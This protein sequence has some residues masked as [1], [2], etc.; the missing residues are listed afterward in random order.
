MKT[1]GLSLE[2]TYVSNSGSMYRVVEINNSLDV[3]IEFI[4]THRYRYSVRAARALSG[5][6]H[7]P[8]QPLKY[9][10]GYMGVG[11]YVSYVSGK[12]TIAYDVWNDMLKR[13][14]SKLNQQTNPTYSGCT[15]HPHW[16]NFQNFAA[17]YCSHPDYNKGY[18]LDK[19]LL[20]KGNTVYSPDTCCLLPRHLNILLQIT[21]RGS[22]LHMGVRLTYNNKYIV[23]VNGRKEG[24]CVG[25]YSTIEEATLA[26]KLAKEKHIRDVTN[27][28]GADLY[29]ETYN[30]LMSYEL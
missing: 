26:Y 22:D 3:L 18:Q 19:D 7:N 1:Y 4:D 10:I 5:S 8:Y 6:V 17:W 2:G 20:V 30:A 25:T 12:N 13:C 11:P 27:A 14:Y 9:G 24:R 15:V 28:I 29:F 23:Q 21:D 16:H